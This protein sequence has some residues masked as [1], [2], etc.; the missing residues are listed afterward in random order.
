[1]GVDMKNINYQLYLKLQFSELVGEW[2]CQFTPLVV[3]LGLLNQENKFN[4]KL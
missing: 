4:D 2:I 3:I 1:M